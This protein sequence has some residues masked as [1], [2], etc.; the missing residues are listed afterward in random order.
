MKTNAL[1]SDGHVLGYAKGAS[2]IHLSLHRNL[3][4]FGWYTHGRSHHLT[5][6]LRTSRQR[7]K[8]KVTRTGAGTPT[9]HS[10]VGFGL[11]N[12][13]PDVDRA[14][15]RNIGLATFRPDG[16]FRGVG[17]AAV[18]FFQRFLKRSEIHGNL[19]LLF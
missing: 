8:Q 16:D 14:C 18:M 19:I 11:V 5:G 2:K 3:N 1:K 17:V 15:Y 4:A 13:A 7:P 10:L 12:G 6:D 9:S